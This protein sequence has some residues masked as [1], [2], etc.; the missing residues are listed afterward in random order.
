MPR[1]KHR[2]KPGGKSLRHPGRGK[3]GR[4]EQTPAETAYS[5][6]CAVYTS[7]FHRRLPGDPLDAGFL[8]DIIADAAFDHG[9]ETLLPVS[10]KM[11]FAEF[12]KPEGSWDGDPPPLPLTIAAAEAALGFLRA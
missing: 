12:T 3:P 9:T 6:F 10:K 1:S 2:R 4:Q 11:A 8:L 5:R 7:P